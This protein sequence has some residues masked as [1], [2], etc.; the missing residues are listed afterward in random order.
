LSHSSRS[1]SL[2]SGIRSLSSTMSAFPL[3]NANDLVS[4]IPHRN[5]VVHPD[6]VALPISASLATTRGTG[7]GVFHEGEIPVGCR[8]AG[9]DGALTART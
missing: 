4:Q 8:I 2:F 7:G 3:T 5:L 6:I 9:L 1:T